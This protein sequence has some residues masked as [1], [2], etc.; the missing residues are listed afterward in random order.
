MKSLRSWAPDQNAWN[1]PGNTE[2][3]LF[4]SKHKSDLNINEDGKN[5]YKVLNLKGKT[6]NIRTYVHLLTCLR[7]INMDIG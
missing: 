2:K 7:Y 3:S 1:K 5:T 4:S 6:N